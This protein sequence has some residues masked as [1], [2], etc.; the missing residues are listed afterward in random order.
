MRLANSFSA[1]RRRPAFTIIELLV[2]IAIIALLAA[3][4]IPSFTIARKQARRLACG[5]NLRAVGN[6]VMLYRT[7]YGQLPLRNPKPIPENIST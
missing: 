4:L 3:L 1:R 6:A 5:V 7:E 2:V